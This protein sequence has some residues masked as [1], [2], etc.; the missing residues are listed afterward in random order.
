MDEPILNEEIMEQ[1]N[2]SFSRKMPGANI[3]YADDALHIA[4]P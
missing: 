2:Q 4:K 1:F 3:L